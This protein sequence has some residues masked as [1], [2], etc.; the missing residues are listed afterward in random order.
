MD[1]AAG[2]RSFIPAKVGPV[3]IV[4][5]ARAVQ[6]ITGPERWV[7]IPHTSE[8]VPGV[9]AWRGRAVAVV[10]LS[11]L[12]QVGEPLKL[13]VTRPRTLLVQAGGCTLAMP[14]DGVREVQEVEPA[15][16]HR[17]HATS[18]PHCAFEVDV[19]GTLAP[20]LDLDSVVS[21]IAQTEAE[22]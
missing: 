20:L 9:L 12:A 7:P 4:V 18:L 11:V 8:L 1:H 2:A 17:P 21:A 5:D 19:M 13:G 16:V 6:E 22:T 14:V 3:W 10:D 15:R